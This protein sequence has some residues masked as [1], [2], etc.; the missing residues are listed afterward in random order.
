MAICRRAAEHSAA[1]CSIRAMGIDRYHRQSLL[2]DF[3]V[4]GQRAITDATV[5]IVGCGA[6][7]CGVADLLARA[8]VG[9]LRIIDR[10]IV[11]PTNLQ[12]QVLFDQCDA[13]EGRP[14]ALAGAQRL[15]RINPEVEVEAVVDD[16]HCANAAA[17][18]DSADVIVDGLDNLEARYLV[19]DLAVRDGLP[20]IYAGAVGTGGLVM[21]ILPSATTFAGRVHWAPEQAG[22][23]LR[24][25]FPEPAPPGTLPTC[26]TAG[27]LGPAVAAVTAHQA[28]LVLSLLIGRIDD[29]DRSLH[30]IDPWLGEDR[31]IRPE[32]PRPDCPCCHGRTFEWLEGA[33]TGATESLCGRNTVQI[34][35]AVAGTLCLED[36]AA[37]LADHGTVRYDDHVLR[38]EL[39]DE[40]IGLTIFPDGRALVGVDEPSRA[41]T[42]YDRFVGN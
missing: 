37:R 22:P 3:G 9:R 42:I 24:C 12:R 17:L 26:D 27:V 39:R 15:I 18:I 16:F 8:G 33:R 28:A 40:G 2:E 23:C 1:R 34:H 11:E 19:N 4:A 30:S 35:P 36:L 38:V 29:L 5:V 25:L 7:G 20:W 32:S 14:K 6:L 41:R 21:P 10:D 31:R 13:D